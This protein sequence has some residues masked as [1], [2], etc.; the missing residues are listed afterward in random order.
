MIKPGKNTTSH[1]EPGSRRTARLLGRLIMRLKRLESRP[2][3]FGEAGSLT[4]SE[5]HTIDAIGCDSG[6]LMGELA[7]ALGVTKGAVTQIVNKLEHKGLVQ[8]IQHPDDSRSITVSL[9]ELGLSAY[10]AHDKVRL[11]FYKQLQEQL[12]DT[13]IKA[14]ERAIEKLVISLKG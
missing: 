14:F 3:N 2:R 6:M 13:E 1:A 10:W 11:G 12:S 4:P 5:I 9:T 7:E 8:R